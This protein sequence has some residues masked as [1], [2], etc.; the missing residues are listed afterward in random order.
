MILSLDGKAGGPENMAADL[1]LM[2]GVEQEGIL[3]RLYDWDGVWVTL[4]KFQRPERALLRPDETKWV[5]RPTGGKAVLHGHDITLGLAASFAS[6][7][8]GPAESRSLGKVYNAVIRPIVAALNDCGAPAALGEDT[9]FVGSR[10]RTADCFAHVAP[11][12]I[13]HPESGAKVMGAA[14]RLSHN[15][16]LVQ[17][18][19]PVRPPLVE[20]SLI[21]DSPHEPAW[22]EGVEPGALLAALERRLSVFSA[23]K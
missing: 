17:A 16:V 20:P 10:G 9:P 8:L 3:A 22:S 11:M 21:F 15:A 5:M 19:I 2:D 13:V 23:S 4:G 1:A 7:G 6:L 14:L 12:D 18:S